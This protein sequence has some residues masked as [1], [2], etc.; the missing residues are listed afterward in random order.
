[1]VIIIYYNIIYYNGYYN[2]S[3]LRKPT[4]EKLNN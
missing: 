4:D 1:M 2:I 3:I